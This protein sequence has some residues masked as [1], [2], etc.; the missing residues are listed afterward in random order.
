MVPFADRPRGAT[1]TTAYQASPPAPEKP[2]TRLLGLGLVLALALGLR[3]WPIEHGLPRNYVPDTHIVRNALGMAKDKNLVPEVGRYSTYPYLLPYV[4][5]PIYVGEYALGRVR[6]EWAGA[7]E[8]GDRLLEE[9]WRAQL[10]AR[11]LVAL[12]GAASVWVVFRAG[13]AMGL[14]GGAW[15]AAWLV[16]TGLL[17]VHLSVQERPWVPMTA[18]MAATLWAAAVHVQSGRRRH[19]FAAGVCAALSFSCHQVG[20]LALGIAGLAWLLGP[21]GW[22]ADELRRRLL[23]GVTCVAVFLVVSLVVG[24]PY[25]LVHGLVDRAAIAAGEHAGDLSI[26]GQQIRF[27]LSSRTLFKLTRALVG[28]DPVLL[29]LGLAG[30]A[31]CWRLRAARPAV[32]FAVAWAAFFMTNQGD[33]VRYLL[34]LVVLLAWPAGAAAENI[35]RRGVRARTL[36]ALALMLPLVQALRL[37]WVLRQEDTRSLAAHWIESELGDSA[38]AVDVHG[39]ELFLDRA[40]LERLASWRELGARERHR[41]SL[42]QAGAETLGGTGLDA[43][44]LEALLDYDLRHR[45]SWIEADALEL[46]ADLNTLLRALGRTHVLVVDRTPDDGHPAMLLDPDPAEP[47]ADG[48]ARPKLAPLD[49]DAEPLARWHPAGSAG[50]LRAARLPAELGFALVELWQLERPGPSIEIFALPR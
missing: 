31:T 17:H 50:S 23:A 27:A 48:R 33:H 42:L 18:C 19:L 29:A 11:W 43:V 47:H 24:H 6:G 30:L 21:S 37:G 22:R 35:W 8:F 25:Y 32:I 34:P 4:L 15:V 2:R 20:V 45:S 3:L 41:S 49:V 39:P 26:G 13:R 44:P 7:G 5:L 28:H 16:A 38:L 9:P 10:P 46:G 40:S 12:C 14:R 36:L 1:I